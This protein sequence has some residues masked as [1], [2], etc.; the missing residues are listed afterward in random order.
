MR[1]ISIAFLSF[2]GV[3][4]FLGFVLGS[5]M[6]DS[7]WFS[8]TTNAAEARRIEAQTQLATREGNIELDYLEQSLDQQ[9][10]DEK[11]DRAQW[12]ALRE[13]G[14]TVGLAGGLGA[15][16]ALTM[17][18]VYYLFCRGQL[19]LAKRVQYARSSRPQATL[20][21]PVFPASKK[22]DRSRSA[23]TASTDVEPGEAA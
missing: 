22:Q 7:D 23:G 16:L 2:V 18:L 6:S 15:L 17:A 13:L 1:A 10:E 5:S 3:L 21:H 11:A 9:L 19:A 14:F 20:V 8:P 12:R 4:V